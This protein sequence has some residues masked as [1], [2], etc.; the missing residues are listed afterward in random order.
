MRLD[1]FS[2]HRVKEVVVRLEKSTHGRQA[3]GFKVAGH[4][5]AGTGNPGDALRKR[6]PRRQRHHCDGA[7][8]LLVLWFLASRRSKVECGSWVQIP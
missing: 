1:P 2:E 8:I 7:N 4:L 3:I 6:E 5:F